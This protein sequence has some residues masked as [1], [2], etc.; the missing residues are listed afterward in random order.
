MGQHYLKT[1]FEAQSVVVFGAS[2]REDSVGGVVFRN[3]LQSG[4]TGKVYA[5][6][7]K[8]DR[9]QGEK[10]Y[11]SL[12][13]LNQPVELAVIA[14]PAATVPAIIDACGA[15][16]VRAVVILSAGFREVGAA[17]LKL[18]KAV[19]ETARR[20]GLRFLGPNCLGIMRPEIGLNA[21][22]NNGSA[23]SGH[24]GL[25]SQSGALCT[26]IL[27]WAA[28]NDVGFSS[29]ISTGISADLDFGEVLD[30]LVSD[31]KTHS[32]LVYIEGIQHSRSFV[33]ALRAAARVKPVILLKV[34]RHAAGSKAA[35]S[36]T[37]ALVGA[38]DVFD[39]AL[40]RAGA[41]R[42][43]RIGD[44]FSAATTLTSRF[45]AQG[46]RLAVVTNG[47]GP[48]VMATDRAEDLGLVM[49]DLSVESME[50]L[51]QALPD[52]WSHGNPIDVIGD[53]PAERYTAALQV[54]LDDTGVD[55]VLVILTPQA[56]TRPLEV[57]RGIIEV[58]KQTKKPVL[59]CW[60]GEVQVAEARQAM[61]AAGLP[62]FHTPEA[63]VEAFSYLAAYHR[64]QQLL[65]QTPGPVGRRTPADTDGARLII[66]GAL[67]EGRKVLS[68]SESKAV[69]AAF[70]IHTGQAVVVRSPA[71]ALVQA[72][73]MGFPVALKINSPDITHK[74]DAGGVHL[75][76]NNAQGV[77][78]AFV[79][80]MSEVQRRRPDARMDGITIE[81]MEQRPNGRELL[82]GLISDPVFGPVI[83]FGAGGTAVEIM[84]DRAVA[85][86]PLNQ[87][88]IDDLISRTRVAKSLDAFRHMPAV[89]R[90]KLDEVLLRISEMACELPWIQELDINPLIVDES[91][92]SAVDAR[93]VVDYPP[94]GQGRYG[95]MAIYPYPAH[96]V[97]NW[98]L[99]NG[100]DLVI[101]PIR[102]EDAEMAQTFVRS[103]S[104]RARYFRFMQHMNELTPSMLAR[105][106]QIDYDREMALVAVVDNDGVDE[107]VGVARYFTNPDA[108]SC[109][110]AVVVLDS[111]QHRGVGH[112]LM[113]QL[114]EAARDDGLREMEGDVLIDN[115]EMLE[116]AHSLGF[117]IS[118]GEEPRV[119]RVSRRL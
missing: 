31:A 119:K 21:T 75:N 109:E 54:C 68:E 88:L 35:Q 102:P 101:R 118:S 63:A 34:G 52:T 95:H 2:D 93:I 41:V 59:T 86:P 46:G 98:Q 87:F 8:R 81:P 1:L 48:G 67:S 56:M 39:A 50:R 9:V 90:N 70:R 10:A 92:A 11:P 83:T 4:F 23:K 60:M 76:I 115:S 51:N 71:E 62:S 18:E 97:S 29:V 106:T 7:P 79:E 15:H 91:G 38:D 85:L 77:R 30:F 22:F 27:D 14:T 16:G 65:L 84:G 105:F 72:E 111:W 36:H 26:A 49:A 78:T 108:Q 5:I 112:R 117:S 25:V 3:M 89:D 80:M 17:G 12:E 24:I 57:A 61:R 94:S 69:L 45:N 20:H 66:E 47:G 82:V 53:A 96:L 99:P 19:L 55:G 113:A 42:G 33:S 104:D 73:N 58:S 40:R 103:L 32:I 43:M 114:L 74:S 28:A 107:Q 44:L 64:N 100:S 110:F 37:G 116:L 6:N 13:A